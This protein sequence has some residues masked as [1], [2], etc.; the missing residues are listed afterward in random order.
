[1]SSRGRGKKSKTPEK[2]PTT[3]TRHSSRIQKLVTPEA[4]DVSS[5]LSNSAEKFLSLKETVKNLPAFYEE[6]K[7]PKALYDLAASIEKSVK[8]KVLGNKDV[9]KNFVEV[10]EIFQVKFSRQTFNSTLVL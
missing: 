2:T 10:Q 5:E 3:G 9:Q 7:L 4:M 1:M 8:G 6:L